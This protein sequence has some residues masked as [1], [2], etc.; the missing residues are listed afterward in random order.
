LDAGAKRIR[1][2]YA[3]GGKSL[4]RV[5]DDGHGITA[6]ELPL[7]L[8]RHA[9]SKTDG[10]DLVHLSTFGFRGEA[11]PSIASV[12]RL[13]LTS[14][15][16]GQDA[17][18]IEARAGEIAT[19]R[20]AARPPGTTVEVRD[21]FA[22]TPARL[23]FLKSDRAEAQAIAET[24]RRLALADPGVAF[25]LVDVSGGG[26]GRTVFRAEA[27]VAGAEGFLDRAERVVSGL[28]AHAVAV[29]G[30][31]E[32]L[33]LT[34]FAGLP[35]FSR[36]SMAAQHLLVNARPVRDRLLGGALR[37]AY[38]DVLARDRHP[39]VVLNLE[40]PP[41]A[42]DVNVHPAKAEVRFRNAGAARALVVS[43]LTQALA[44]AGHRSA[45][46]V[47]AFPGRS[48][49]TPSWQSARP[50]LPSGAAVHLG[51][52]LQRPAQ[53]GPPPGFAEAPTP[54]TEAD[55]PPADPAPDLPLGQPRAQLHNLY[56]V[57]ETRD[58]V[59]LIDQHA[60]HE[61]LVYERLKSER[62]A[63][64]VR[65]QALLIPE[66][67]DL[68]A[69]A[70]ERVLA[71]APELERLGLEVEA[72]GGTSVCVRAV[73]A[74]LG[75]PDAASLLHD[76]ADEL[77]EQGTAD[78]L[79]ARLDAVAS[80]M[81]CHGSVRAGRKL[82]LAEMDALLREMEATPRSGQCNHGR[83]T[84]ITLTLAE[85]ERLFGRRG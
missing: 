46:T 77:A 10:A 67:V 11:L 9:T 24:V 26:E 18:Q 30:E 2:A 60:A 40:C 16:P 54:P 56:I 52:D 5:E 50:A 71:A 73:P 76:L 34:G 38:R 80:R 13:S 65:R 32:G 42:V 82:G 72:F 21:L 83:P 14:R 33:R 44:E 78:T 22:A 27:E 37:A 19:P 69:E 17:W 23:R 84:S 70:T 39:V 75:Q 20:P 35:T 7:A 51:L 49:G 45:A 62:A 31:R 25:H 47:P 48:G 63:T 55:S 79:E 4:I 53:P 61:R 8:E 58:G 57:A 28:K 68:E 59:V 43:A 6:T 74:V 36:A 12:S 29:L 66:I 85:I 81:A 41:E 1:I 64:G 3:E 15:V